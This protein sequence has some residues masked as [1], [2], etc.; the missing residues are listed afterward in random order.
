MIVNGINLEQKF[1]EFNADQKT[2]HST[3][4]LASVSEQSKLEKSN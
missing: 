2:S 4:L 3:R 1:Q